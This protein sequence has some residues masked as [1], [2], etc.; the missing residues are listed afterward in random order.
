MPSSSHLSRESAL[1]ISNPLSNRLL[2]ANRVNLDVS[3]GE[4]E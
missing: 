1:L 2:N 3:G 4:N